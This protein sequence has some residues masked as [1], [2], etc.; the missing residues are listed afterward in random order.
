M[1]QRP[2]GAV[3][4]PFCGMSSARANSPTRQPLRAA[5][6]ARALEVFFFIY[7]YMP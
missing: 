5:R 7:C 3:C 4:R 2:P 6:C 1:A